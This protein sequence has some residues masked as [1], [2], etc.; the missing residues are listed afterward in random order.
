MECGVNSL[1]RAT[2][3]S[4]KYCA[5]GK[6]LRGNILHGRHS[7]QLQMSMTDSL[8]NSEETA[9]T[10]ARFGFTKVTKILGLENGLVL[11]AHRSCQGLPPLLCWLRSQRALPQC[12]LLHEH[13]EDR[14]QN[15][16]MDR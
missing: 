6:L 5:F 16:D 10:F 14:H 13:E 12:S 9:G 1:S 7:S 2:N 3:T 15:Q 8:K 4:V 11:E